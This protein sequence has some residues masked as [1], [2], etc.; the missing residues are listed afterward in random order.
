MAGDDSDQGT[1]ID[2]NQARDAFVEHQGR[3]RR[4]A[5]IRTDG[6]GR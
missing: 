1:V 4:D 5:P 3:G 2:D 6:D